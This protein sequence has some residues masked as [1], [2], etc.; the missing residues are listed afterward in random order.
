MQLHV[1]GRREG[2]QITPAEVKSPCTP[3]GVKSTFMPGGSEVALYTRRDFNVAL[4]AQR[5]FKVARVGIT[6]VVLRL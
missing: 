5:D 4:Y 3:V 1:E 2:C 6:A